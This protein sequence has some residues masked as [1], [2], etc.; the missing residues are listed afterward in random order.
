MNV[1]WSLATMVPWWAKILAKLLLAR[2]RLPYRAWRK[3]GFFLHGAMEDPSYAW[4]VYSLHLAQYQKFSGKAVPGE[5]LE[6]GPGDSAFSGA[7]GAA[8]G[9]RRTVLVDVESF[10]SWNDRSMKTLRSFLFRDHP[11]LCLPDGSGLESIRTDYLTHGLESLRSLP[12]ASVDFIWS[13]AVLEHLPREAFPAFLAEMRRIVRSD[14][15]LSHRVDLKDHLGGGLNNLRFNDSIWESR[16]FQSSGFYT[17]R[18]RRDEIL[19]A[20]RQAGF[21]V[22]LMVEERWSR[23]PTRK[24][25]LNSAFRLRSDEE[26]L[27]SGLNLVLRPTEG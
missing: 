8:L 15:L 26:L 23:M 20:F 14:G 7:F 21:E 22:V 9:T 19:S 12:E 18:L 10:F 1:R 17:N 3:M 11:N 16:W 13:Q 4:R 2:F 25:K 5:V 24:N 6:L 27:V